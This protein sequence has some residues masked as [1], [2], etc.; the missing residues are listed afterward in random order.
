MKKY[1][2]GFIQSSIKF[3]RNRW[4]PSYIRAVKKTVTKFNGFPE[5]EKADREF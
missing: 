5:P 3:A 2:S 4:L 1:G